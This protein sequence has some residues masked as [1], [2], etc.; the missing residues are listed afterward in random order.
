LAEYLLE[1][2]NFLAP[3]LGA[4]VQE[5]VLGLV[6]ED[7]LKCRPGT[8]VPKSAIIIVPDLRRGVVLWIREI[9]VPF[10]V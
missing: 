4:D 10:R 3:S 6:D 9:A 7:H 1:F 8:P 5:A 2:L